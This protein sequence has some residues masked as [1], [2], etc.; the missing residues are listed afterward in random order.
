MVQLTTLDLSGNKI[1]A[2]NE[3]LFKS[4]KNLTTLNLSNNRLGQGFSDPH[5]NFTGWYL[6]FLQGFV[7]QLPAS[8][9]IPTTC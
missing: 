8:L 3:H 2:F 9:C 1:S 4:M 7:S 6:N 5:L